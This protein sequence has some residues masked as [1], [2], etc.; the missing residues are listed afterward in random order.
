MRHANGNANVKP[1]GNTYGDAYAN[2]DSYGGGLSYTYSDSYSYRHTLTHADLR[3]W[4]HAW[5]V[6]YCSAG[7]T[8]S[9]SRRWMH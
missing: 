7:A 4:W 5:A 6:G 3:T 2:S 9:L 1:N 8:R